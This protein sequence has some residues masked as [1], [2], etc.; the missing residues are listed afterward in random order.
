MNIYIGNLSYQTI[1]QD[2]EELFATYGEVIRAHVVTDRETGRSRGFG[3]VEMVS[4]EAGEQAI[5]ALHD[6]EFMERNL[7]INEA[8]PREQKPRRY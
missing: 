7:N 1:N 4:K 5:A 2:L 6:Q 3:F 8:L